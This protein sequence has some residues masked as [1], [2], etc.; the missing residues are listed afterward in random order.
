MKWLLLCGAVILSLSVGDAKAA[1][2]TYQNDGVVTYPGALQ[3]PPVIDATNF[4]NNNTMVVNYTT[5]TLYTPNL[6]ETSDTVN[7][8]N[9]GLMMVNS[10]FLFDNRSGISGS[11]TSSA[12]F[13]N[14]GTISSGSV[15]NLDDPYQGFLYLFGI[16]PQCFINATNIANPGNITVGQDGRI[17]MLGKNIDLTR[18][19]L[20]VESNTANDAGTGTFGLNTNFWDPSFD[21][22]AGFAQS[23]FFPVSPFFLTLTNSEAYIEV[24]AQG[25]SNSIIRAV[26]IQDD[27]LAN[28][29]YNVYLGNSGGVGGDGTA[30]IEWIGSYID[31]ASGGVASNYLYLNNNYIRSTATNLFLFN[32]I[33]D[34]FTFTAS[35][36]PIDL[37]LA[38]TAAGFQDV[39][40]AG[41]V[42]NRYSYAEAQL[43]STSVDTNSIPNHSVTNLPGRVEISAENNLKLAN[44]VISGMNYMSI[45]SPY[46]FDG[47]QGATIRAPYSDINIGVTNGF[48][49]VTN[50]ISASIP[51]WS[52][53][54][55]AWSTRWLEEVGGVT[56][57]Y[58]VLIVRSQLNPQSPAVVQD[59]ALHGTNTIVISDTFNIMRKFTADAKNLILTTNP[60]GN[61]ATSFAGELNVLSPNI[62][63]AS[64]LPNLRNMTNDG[65]IRLQN[66]AQFIGTSNVVSATPSSPAIA[67]FGVLS[68][69][70]TNLNVLAGNQTTIGTN[71]YAFVTSLNNAIP[72]QVKIG[73]KFDAS[74]SNLIAAI[75]HSSGSGSIYS[76]STKT[77][78]SVMAGVLSNHTFQVTARTAGVAGNTIVTTNSTVTT[79]LTWG[80]YV[81]LHGGTEAVVGSTNATTTSVAYDNLVN[82][83]LISDQGTTA[84]V[85]YFENTGI[86]TNG[87]GSFNLQSQLGI[88]TG[89]SV[90][91]G[92]DVSIASA[93]LLVSNVYIQSGRSLVLTISTNGYL[94]DGGFGNSNVW[95][96]GG[97]AGVG[98]SM[99]KRPAGGD[100]LGTTIT[101]IAPT[102]KLVFNYWS[103]LDYGAVPAGYTNNQALGRLI[104]ASYGSSPQFGQFYYTGT[105]VS[106]ALYVD[107]LELTEQATNFNNGSIPELVINSNLVIYY[108]Q[109]VANGTSVAKKLNGLNGG[110]LRWVSN[111]VGNFSYTT[112][113]Y[114][115]G[116]TNKFNAALAADNAIDSDGD[117]T[118]NAYDPTPFFVDSQVN[119]ALSVVSN[120]PALKLQFKWN[121]IPG[122]TSYIQFSSNLPPVWKA[123]LTN[124]APSTVPPV[125]G[126]PITNTFQF[127]PTGSVSGFYRVKMDTK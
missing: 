54:V 93:N 28:V 15:D 31:P 19:A 101:N 49:S 92:A 66:L 68:E 126:W 100:L 37:G 36:V 71:K 5:I 24:T 3:S 27:S 91:A 89:G 8:T 14:Q 119:F 83:G 62:F 11:R 35:D 84:N 102:N 56:N 1:D 13:Y 18:T 82:H 104:L 106:N 59:L 95:V 63:W 12:N 30:T 7:Y 33:P 86:I 21:L 81:T 113:V 108:A 127:A 111:Y 53:N 96:T 69:A 52:G 72:N 105:G 67:A 80:G 103:S 112:I 45:Q 70:K 122:A 4:I 90:Y 88:F 73:T 17:Q 32:G 51:N 65:A 42:T 29:S 125:G 98:L 110:H 2:D 109:A 38:P 39:F 41:A 116:T 23:A 55:Q 44:A 118:Y 115:D 47:S 78:P 114:P 43:I 85:N 46:Q 16:Y 25:A 20:K 94:T 61:G 34:N 40:A 26:F 60:V 99:P 6:F 97:A 75:N 48:L 79:N 57:D 74:M 64:A 76:S 50:L 10:G 120:T 77:N 117:G 121:S 87:S 107:Y 22:G 9:N 58:R 124:V 123:V